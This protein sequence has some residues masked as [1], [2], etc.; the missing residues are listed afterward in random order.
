MPKLG[1]LEG[2]RMTNPLRVNRRV[3]W[4]A[5][6]GLSLAALAG[7]PVLAR[8]TG[9]QPA[10]GLDGIEV[11][12]R[13]V[14]GHPLWQYVA[15]VIWVALAFGVAAL[16]DYLLAGGV[17][18]L[19]QR[20]KT[21]LPK[22]LLDA[23]R[24]PVKLAVVLGILDAGVRTLPWPEWVQNSLSVLF[25]IA[26]AATVTYLAVRLVDLVAVYFHG[27]TAPSDTE[28]AKLLVPVLTRMVKLFVIGIGALTAAQYLG[29]PVT[30]VIAGL[31]IGGVAVAL[32]AQ[33]TLANVFGTISI[34]MDRPFH[35]GDQVQVDKYEGAVAMI[36]LRSTRVRTLE[37]HVVT[38][39][40]K[41]MADSAITN[42]S[43]RPA[44][45]QRM[46]IS[47]T[48][49][50]SAARM[51]EAV[52]LLREIFLK[53]PL[54]QDA[55]VYWKGYT[56]SSLEIAVV[57]W[58]RSTVYREFL[59][60]VEELNVEIKRGLDGAGLRFAF[61]TQTIRL[62]TASEESAPAG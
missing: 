16:V 45:R 36:G 11:L 58:C 29:L 24:G 34:L 39:P 21:E 10:F 35:V 2:R 55:W 59:Q 3:S 26:V 9:D 25:T 30:S 8:I 44:I 51:Q 53:H 54:T 41:I 4:P 20:S 15:A 49:D 48:Y 31:G 33:S 47:L 56:A 38:I 28:L 22:R 6:A 62:Q 61:P 50:T 23:V 1:G 43:L 5:G 17:R 18:R 40:N 32:A 12:Q 42:I 7:T 46:T 13:P 57:Y 37:G 19:A 52:A 60:A 14:G 27:R